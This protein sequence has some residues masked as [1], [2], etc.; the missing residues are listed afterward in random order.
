MV[1]AAKAGAEPESELRDCPVCGAAGPSVVMPLRDYLGPETFTLARCGACGTQYLGDPPAP[2]DLA[3]YYATSAG[4]AMRSAP[5]RLFTIA[6]RG[7]IRRDLRPLLE[8]LSPGELVADVGTGD[9]SVARELDAGGYAA[10]GVDV[11]PPEEWAQPGIPYRSYSIEEGLDAQALEVDGRGPA[12]AV[13]R[14]VLEHVPEPAET[15]RSLHR[16]GTRNVLIIVPN[17]GS[18]L[19][20]RLG[21]NWYYWDPPR[22]LTFFTSATLALLADRCGYRVDHLGTYGLDELACSAHRA[23]LIAHGGQMDRLSEV[24]RPTG[25]VAGASSALAGGVA[26]TVLHVVLT[27]KPDAP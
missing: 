25:I 23:R 1:E 20:G 7:R 12:A 26:D 22:H 3:P 9:G 18:R 14:H 24:L 17:A 21:A 11:Y 2:A 6:R 19:A 13:L 8:R 16:A 10:V 5:G 4:A 27:R 15:L